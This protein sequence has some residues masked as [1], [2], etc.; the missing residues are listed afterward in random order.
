[1]AAYRRTSGYR[2][3]MNQRCYLPRALV[4]GR[5]LMASGR[6]YRVAFAGNWVRVG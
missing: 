1:M 4:D 3:W 6:M 5:L 2:N